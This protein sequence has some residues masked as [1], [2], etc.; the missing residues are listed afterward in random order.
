MRAGSVFSVILAKRLV[1]GLALAGMALTTA[2][3]PVADPMRPPDG[4]QGKGGAEAAPPPP[5]PDLAL[6]STLVAAGRRS[7]VINGRI[8]G[9]GGVIEGVRVVGITPSR[10]RLRDARG[11][12]TLRLPSVG[13]KRDRD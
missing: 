2:A 3:E 8:V 10:V 1:T 4:A 7:A 6:Q 5:R 12:F 9:V 11:T 13:M